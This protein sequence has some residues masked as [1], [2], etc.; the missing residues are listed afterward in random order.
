MDPY[1]TILTESLEE[2][3]RVLDR[4]E[5]ADKKETEIL[6]GEI[7]D[8]KAFDQN[9]EEKRKLI[10][11]LDRLDDGFEETF[12]LVREELDKNREAHREE[13][14]R[15]QALIREITEKTV[16][17]GAMESRNRDTVNVKFKKRRKEIGG[18]RTALKAANM[19]SDNMRR[20]N[21]IDSF[22]VDKKSK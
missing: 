10:E 6:A 3:S 4:I 20:I 2:K 22:F 17:I 11:T 7:P 14:L 9:M 19:Y 8:L 5:E 12:A 16:R 13:I 1:I 18:K 21:K 15:L